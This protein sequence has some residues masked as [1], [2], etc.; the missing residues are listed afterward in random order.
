MALRYV[1]LRH[2]GVEAPHFDLMFECDPGSNLAT[3]RSDAWPI[4]DPTPLKKLRNHR[5]EFLSFEG[6]LTGN[7]GQVTQIDAGA[8]EK[9]VGADGVWHLSLQGEHGSTT[10][11]LI[12]DEA[13]EERWTA[14]RI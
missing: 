5:R 3:W 4:F 6:A 1:V 9:S 13:N 10:L 12:P 14:R 11:W 8:F 2:E 7:R